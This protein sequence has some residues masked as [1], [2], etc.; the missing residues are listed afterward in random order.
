MRNGPNCFFECVTFDTGGNT[1]DPI[2][3]FEHAVRWKEARTCSFGVRDLTI[4]SPAT[5]W[6]DISATN[7]YCSLLLF[8]RWSRA[9]GFLNLWPICLS[10]DFNYNVLYR[11]LRR[12]LT[13]L[14]LLSQY[15]ALLSSSNWIDE[16]PFVAVPPPKLIEYHTK[17]D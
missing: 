1:F 11:K 6:L 2:S 12:K 4:T 16:R 17:D 8:P 13:K 5:D 3:G 7:M 10:I 14:Q 9:K 15:L